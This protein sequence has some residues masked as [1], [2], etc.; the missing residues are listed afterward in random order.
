M[1][2]GVP[3]AASTSSPDEPAARLRR[4]VKLL[5]AILGEVLVESRDQSL[6]DDVER[7]RQAVIGRRRQHRSGASGGLDGVLAMV[8]RMSL[9]R[10]AEV[11]RAFTVYFQLV[12]LAEERQ[13][14]RMLRRH[15]RRPT[16]ISES[17][18]ATLERLRRDLG[19]AGIRRELAEL[20]II[21]VLTAHPTE[22]RRRSV[23]ESLHRVSA[24]LEVLEDERLGEVAGAEAKRRLR[25]EVSALWR[26]AQIRSRRPE[27]E[28]EVRTIT[29]VFDESLFRLLPRFYRQI[30]RAL[31][32]DADSGARAPGWEPFLKWGSWVGGDR[33]GNPLVTHDVTEHAM[34]I[35]FEHVM[36]GLEAASRRV[37]RALSLSDDTTPPSPELASALRRTGAVLKTASARIERIAPGQSHRQFLVLAS[38]RLAA[39]RRA[40]RAAYGA[41]SE[42]LAD[43]FLLQDSLA[44]AGAARLAYGEVQHLIWQ[45]QTFGFHLASLEIRQHSGVHRQALRELLPGTK[46]DAAGLDRLGLKA[47]PLSPD[48][49]TT[50]ATAETLA[51]FKSMARIQARLGPEACR[52]YVVSFTQSAA[53]IVAVFALARLAVADQELVLDA[54]PLFESAQ[55]LARA[56]Q[57]LDQL[58]ALPGFAARLNA[59]DRRFEVM[60]GYSDAT[61]ESGYLAANLDLYGAQAA[62][63]VWAQRNQV[64]LT[65]FHG[66]GGAI[67]RGGGPAGRAVRAQ[68]SG[69]I[70]GRLKVTEQGEV[71]FARYRDLEIGQRHLEQLT[72]AVLEASTPEHQG[73]LKLAERR[74]QKESDLMASVSRAAYRGLLESPGFAEFVSRVSPLDEITALPIGSRPARRAAPGRRIEDLRAIP[75]VFAW[76]QN[77]CNLTG[78]FGLGSALDA[79][80]AKY[81]IEHLRRMRAEWPL[82][83][84]L[85]DNAEMSLAKADPTIA[86]LYLDLGGRPELTASLGREFQL[87]RQLLLAVLE[88]ERLLGGHPVLRS[89]VDLR[90]PYVDALSLLQLRF[91]RGYRSE[92]ASGAA[93]DHLLQLVLL[94]V[95]GVAAGL[96]NTG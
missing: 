81:G 64:Q 71:I 11:A 82:F 9:G 23:V 44:R 4:E 75:F 32:G 40:R 26:T 94:T 62:L 90:N 13:R 15:S 30:D 70:S 1:I 53:D 6:L 52:R 72:S 34:A 20:E 28:D 46:L 89:A 84:S 49:Q 57:I 8:D 93:R 92:N 54:V 42:F 76:T 55:D 41:A 50:A 56:P 24:E 59:R 38:E 18:R 61:K 22:A 17:V 5:G 96:Q 77:R 73:R 63:W 3:A 29:A 58:L 51:V 21:P 12:N 79:V 35:Q 16:P 83:S 39:T 25:E 66:R 91:L 33:D 27:P 31:L 45:V 36:T 78:W 7:L 88:Q 60:L 37:G 67:G 87:T 43:L 19:E 47:L 2:R 65:F 68:A 80:Q 14:V 95:N 74:Y 10:A 69:S 85:L 48:T 86:G